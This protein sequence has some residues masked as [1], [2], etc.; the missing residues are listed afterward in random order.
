[1]S[2][3]LDNCLCLFGHFPFSLQ[4][5]ECFTVLPT[6]QEGSEFRLFAPY[7]PE[8]QLIGDWNNWQPIPMKTVNL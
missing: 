3:V 4:V 8:V 2:I 6:M 1:V 7:N 5:R